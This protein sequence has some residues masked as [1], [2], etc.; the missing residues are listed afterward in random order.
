MHDRLPLRVFA[1]AVRSFAVVDVTMQEGD[2][3]SAPDDGDGEEGNRDEENDGDVSDA[4]VAET[5]SPG[6]APGPRE[7]N[8]NQTHPYRGG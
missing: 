5:R 6:L 3:D 2:S 4:E 1:A 7:F 8:D